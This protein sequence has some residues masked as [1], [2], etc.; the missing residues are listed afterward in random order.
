MTTLPTLR[1][2]TAALREQHEAWSHP[3]CGG[4]YVC[5]VDAGT[6]VGWVIE[7]AALG[8]STS[9]ATARAS[10]RW[11]RRGGCSRRRGTGWRHD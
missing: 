3:D 11:R 7:T 2:L 9:R 8:E 1:A 10:M 6:E 5:L 4:E